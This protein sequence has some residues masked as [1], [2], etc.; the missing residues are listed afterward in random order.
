MTS[1]SGSEIAIRIVEKAKS[2]GASLAGV[3][4]VDLLKQS[5]SHQIYP[6][7]EHNAGVGSRE[8]AQGIRPGEVA[9][10]ND[11]KSA[12]VIAVEHNEDRP[13]LDW[14][15]GKKSPPGNR[16]LIKINQTLSAWIEEIFQI[17]THKLPYHIEK[18]GIFLKD[19]A[20]VAGM[21]CIG[22]NNILV[23]PEFGPRVR[24]RALLLDQEIAPTGPTDFDPCDG[25]DEPCRQAC[26]QRAF[27]KQI[28]SPV[29]MGLGQLPGRSGCFSRPTCNQQMQADIDAAV[30]DIDPESG[31]MEKIIKYCRRCELACPVGQ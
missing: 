2:L 6:K 3:A 4:S 10:P 17:T 15:Y 20:V 14:W 31:Q 21:G 16:I 12:V 18:G 22:K 11:A 27:D 8:S 29:E 25:C 13:D 9:W 1:P 23:T 19:S 26:P 7:M 24:L 30:E 28:F 5:P